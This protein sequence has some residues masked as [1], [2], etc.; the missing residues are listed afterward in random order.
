MKL[1]FVSDEKRRFRQPEPYR[2]STRVNGDTG[3]DIPGLCDLYFPDDAD[4][5]ATAAKV[6]ELP[7]RDIVDVLVETGKLSTAQRV[8]VRQGV[9]TNPGCALEELLPKWQMVG[10][11]DVLEAKAKLYG[12]EFR[13]IRPEE[14]DVAAFRMLD[15]DFLRSNR[16]MPIGVDGDNL[17]VA[18]SEP[19][20]VFVMEEVRKRTQME[21]RLL[22]CGKN[23][24]S[25]ACDFFQRQPEPE[26]EPAA[27]TFEQDFVPEIELIEDEPT[28]GQAPVEQIEQAEQPAGLTDIVEEEE[29]T[30][31]N[32]AAAEFVSFLMATVVNEGAWSR[33]DDECSAIIMIPF[34]IEGAIK[35]VDG[36]A[37]IE[38]TVELKKKGAEPDLH[39][40][41]EESEDIII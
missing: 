40:V 26:P 32:P 29:P 1:P 12:V 36:V 31:L 38:G 8:Q 13:R 3:R 25:N 22:V 41:G 34:R 39:P 20:N 18:T 17:V 28:I 33:G 21:L 15:I 10:P 6:S 30:P 7:G 35:I 5:A 37:S 23:D 19:E 24:V 11:E 4:R 14:V 9:L 2:I 16:I 27:Q